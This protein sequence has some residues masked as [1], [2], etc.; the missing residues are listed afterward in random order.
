MENASKALIIA[1][2]V[3]I[4]VALISIFLYVFNA[5]GQYQNQTQAQQ[6][7]NQV[8][9][10]NRFFVESAY[11]LD[12]SKAGV[13]IYG[14]DVYNLMRK[15]KDINNNPDAENYIEMQSPVS[16]T[17]FVNGTEKNEDNLKKKYTYSYSFDS[18]GY[19]NK[20]TFSE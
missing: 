5:I 12:A 2:T 17:S 15:A 3:L 4:T 6:Q 14:Y 9:A 7:S 11:D 16:E 18:E 1:G 19:I 8:I 13:Q 20:I 10:A